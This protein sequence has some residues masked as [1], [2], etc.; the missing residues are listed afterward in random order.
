MAH[1][2]QVQDW[3]DRAGGREKFI[4]KMKEVQPD[5]FLKEGFRC[6]GMKKMMKVYEE[7]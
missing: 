1:R 2:S 4:E 5:D 7:L 6:Y 3:V